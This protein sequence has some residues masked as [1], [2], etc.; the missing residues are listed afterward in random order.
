MSKSDTMTTCRDCQ[1]ATKYRLFARTQLCM[2]CLMIR[3]A[4]PKTPSDQGPL[5]THVTHIHP[6]DNGQYCQRGRA[7]IVQRGRW[8]VR[9]VWRDQSEGSSWTDQGPWLGHQQWPRRPVICN[10]SKRALMASAY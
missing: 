3:L 7:V 4:A 8:H 6:F 2:P 10:S 1:K 9:R 5:A